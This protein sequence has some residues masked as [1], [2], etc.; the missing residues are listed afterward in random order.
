MRGILDVQRD[1]IPVC[2]N[3]RNGLSALADFDYSGDKRWPQGIPDV[4]L[5][6]Q[7]YEGAR[8][9]RSF[10]GERRLILAVLADAVSCLLAIGARSE[11]L[12]QEARD[13]I[14]GRGAS[15]LPFREACEALELD[16]DATRVGIQTLV[17]HREGS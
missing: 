3:R 15:P 2:R 13:W 10:C 17:H 4:T 16:P 11:R 12:R 1:G 9:A 14:A 5:P 8:R 7:F 6:I